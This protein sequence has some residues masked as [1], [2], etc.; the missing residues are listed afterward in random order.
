MA[1]YY[2]VFELNPTTYKNTRL[3]GQVMSLV[4]AYNIAQEGGIR[5]IIKYKDDSGF[6]LPIWT[7]QSGIK[8][9][10]DSQD[11][12]IL[13]SLTL[14]AAK[15]Y[16]G[17]VEKLDKRH[18]SHQLFERIDSIAQNII[19][20][21]I[22]DFAKV[23]VARRK[24]NKRWETRGLEKKYFLSL[25]LVINK[26]LDAYINPP[27]D[28][29]LVYWHEPG[30]DEVIYYGSYET[31][32][33]ARNSLALLDTGMAQYVAIIEFDGEVKRYLVSKGC[34][35]MEVVPMENEEQG[36]TEK[37]RM[38]SELVNFVMATHEMP[39]VPGEDE[40]EDELL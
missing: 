35:P 32:A 30:A 18:L 33:E 37:K 27:K 40:D 10:I 11:K 5:K 31:F 36:W 9:P 6:G 7:N 39:P 29:A 19:W 3:T 1:P 4:K 24:F 38:L 8:E 23:S 21:C 15:E 13:Q 20:A 28:D 26:V 16:R 22:P 14:D 2:A 12:K 17:H 25:L 34:G